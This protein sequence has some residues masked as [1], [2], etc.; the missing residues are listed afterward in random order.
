[1]GDVQQ[2]RNVIG[3]FEKGFQGGKR[4]CRQRVCTVKNAIRSEL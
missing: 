1:M 4:F 3:N 2:Q